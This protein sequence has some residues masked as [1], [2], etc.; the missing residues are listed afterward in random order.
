[1]LNLITPESRRRVLEDVD[2]GRVF[3]LSVDYFVGMPSWTAN[4]DMG[5][6]SG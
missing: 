5:S 1:M 6:R 4:G 2:P 3:D